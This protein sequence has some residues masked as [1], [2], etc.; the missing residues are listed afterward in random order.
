LNTTYAAAGLLASLGVEPHQMAALTIADV[1]EDASAVRV[2]GDVRAIQP[3]VRGILRSHL[4]Q[5]LLDGAGD[6]D[7]LLV[8][9]GRREFRRRGQYSTAPL[10][11]QSAKQRLRAITAET[12]LALTSY[13]S[14]HPRRDDRQWVKRRGISVQVL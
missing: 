13:W 8:R 7:G 5:R 12:G 3:S 1:G 6:N 11:L 10:S 2:G 14:Q 4:A 9:P